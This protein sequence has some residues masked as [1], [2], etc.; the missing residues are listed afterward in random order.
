M[1]HIRP[2]SNPSC[3]ELKHIAF[4]SHTPCYLE[5]YPGAWSIC[6]LGCLDWAQV[7]WTIKS[8]FTQAFVESLKGTV[9]VMLGCGKKFSLMGSGC[10]TVIVKLV[11]V[12]RFIRLGKRSTENGLVLDNLAGYVADELA[13]RLK[14][15]ND[16]MD[17]FAYASN[18]TNNNI[19]SDT[20]QIDVLLGDKIAL[21]LMDNEISNVKA[22]FSLENTTKDFADAV[23]KG[24]LHDM[25]IGN[26]KVWVTGL[27]ACQDMQCEESFLNVTSIPP[28]HS[29]ATCFYGNIYTIV[30][31]MATFLWTMAV[32]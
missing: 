29:L 20:V 22:N 28:P 19:E 12:R 17:W 11:L 14:W 6:E 23:E 16:V 26:D 4:D 25:V 18:N 27:S 13:T 5:A 1:P 31:P 8:G 7:F 32:A 2:W 30:I 10:P 9:D 15:D 21:E 24:L 3:R